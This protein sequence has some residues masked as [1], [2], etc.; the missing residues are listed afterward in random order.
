LNTLRFLGNR[1]NFLVRDDEGQDLD[2]YVFLIGGS[3]LKGSATYEGE[4]ISYRLS[5]Q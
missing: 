1:I 5:R 3:R 4:T 2:S